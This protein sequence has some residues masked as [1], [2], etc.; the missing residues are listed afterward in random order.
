MAEQQQPT[1]TALG[2]NSP[3]GLISFKLCLCDI[4]LYSVFEVLICD[5]SQLIPI[6]TVDWCMYPLQYLDN[7]PPYAAA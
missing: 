7:T 1:T 6:P 3:A 2:G 4:S 5:S